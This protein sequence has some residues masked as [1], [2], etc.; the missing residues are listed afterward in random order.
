[1]T[2]TVWLPGTPPVRV[3]QRGARTA[4][5]IPLDE[6][7][8]VANRISTDGPASEEELIQRLSDEFGIGR[9]TSV[10]RALLSKLV[11]S[12][13]FIGKAR[14]GSLQSVFEPNPALEAEH[15]LNPAESD[16]FLNMVVRCLPTASAISRDSLFNLVAGALELEMSRQFRSD[17]NA[18]IS[19]GVTSGQLTVDG[20]LVGRNI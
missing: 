15:Y 20:F 19:R 10:T 16:L 1:M 8:A 3:R 2:R 11:V 5:E 13:S 14:P 17:V 12:S 18:A 6:I 7:S 4:A 9:L